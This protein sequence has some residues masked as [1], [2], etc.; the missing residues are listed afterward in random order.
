MRLIDADR[1]KE[2]I[3]ERIRTPRSTMEIQKDILPLLNAQPNASNLEY[4]IK[5]TEHILKTD[6]WEKYYRWCEEF[7]CGRGS[8]CNECKHDFFDMIDMLINRLMDEREGESDV[9]RH[10]VVG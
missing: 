9:Q 4:V 6:G 5:R 10:D 1:L 3:A 8:D 2:Q 7:C